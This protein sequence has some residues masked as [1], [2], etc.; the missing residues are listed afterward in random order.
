MQIPTRIGLLT[1]ALLFCGLSVRAQVTPS[2]GGYLFRLKH[3]KGAKTRYLMT[4]NISSPAVPGGASRVALI[5]T[6]NVLDVKDGIATIRTEIGGM[7]INGKPAPKEATAQVPKSVEIKVNDQGKVISGQSVGGLDP[8]SFGGNLPKKPIKVGET[9]TD[10]Q[11][12]PSQMGK[13]TIKVSTTLVGIKS[14]G[15]RK[16][17]Q[18]KVTLSGDQS[19]M[20][21]KGSGTMLIDMADGAPINVNMTQNMS[22]SAPNGQPMQMKMNITMERK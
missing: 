17:A 19:P 11:S 3:V 10:T 18:M 22:G 12:V 15:N 14:V 1:V 16:V 2:G 6:Q 13:M 20:Q 7:T 4:Q 9:F 21:I 5:M 8:S